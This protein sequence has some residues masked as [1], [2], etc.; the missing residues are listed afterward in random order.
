M[1]EKTYL[2]DGGNDS[3]WCRNLITRRLLLIVIN[4]IIYKHIPVTPRNSK[5]NTK[6]THISAVVTGCMCVVWG[7]AAVPV[8]SLVLISVVS[9]AS[10]VVPIIAVLGSLSSTSTNQE[11]LCRSWR[12]CVRAQHLQGQGRGQGQ[13]VKAMWVCHWGDMEF[14]VTY[15][16]SVCGTAYTGGSL[17]LC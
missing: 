1:E 10:A 4:E 12:G 14:K 16:P 8:V 5:K 11:T 17:A 15:L 2:L 7:W 6:Q 3:I 9:G 13:K